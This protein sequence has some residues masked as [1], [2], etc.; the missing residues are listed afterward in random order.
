[1]YLIRKIKHLL[2]YYLDI[3]KNKKFIE[4]H[5]FPF[6]PNSKMPKGAE[7]VMKNSCKILS[8]LGVNFRIADG[9]I[10][11]LYRAG[12][13]I[14][15]DNDIDV[16]VFDDKEVI[17]IQK[18]FK[19]AGMTLGRKAIYNGKIQQLVYYTSDYIIFD[20]IVWHL[21]DKDGKLYN[22]SERDYER[23]QDPKYFEK[24]KLEF[25]EFRGAKYPIPTPIEE[26][27]EMRYGNDWKIPKTYKGDWK[28]ECFDMKR[29][30]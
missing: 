18:S 24:D 30:D 16:E 3:L 2:K 14:A 28:D 11:G 9:T 17:D 19:E 8:D 4:F 10:L 1:M 5:S 13:F 25:I 26:W 22:Y 21:N 23:I 29:I 27:L 15:H 12:E 6:D 7:K 20:I